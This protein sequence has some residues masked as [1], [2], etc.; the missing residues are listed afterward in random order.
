[1]NNTKGN[2]ALCPPEE[3]LGVNSAM[4]LQDNT[5]ICHARLIP[6]MCGRQLRRQP[7]KLLRSLTSLSNRVS[8]PSAS[9][10]FQHVIACEYERTAVINFLTM[11]CSSGWMS[12]HVRSRRLINKS[13]FWS[14]KPP[15]FTRTISQEFLRPGH[16]R[17][18]FIRQ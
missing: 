4:V 1:M 2:R 5:S 12:F 17:R 15:E 18:I 9:R 10:N 11:L 13:D 3:A 6:G 16:V 7:F 8:A 14:T